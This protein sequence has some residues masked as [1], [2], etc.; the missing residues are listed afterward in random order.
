MEIKPNEHVALSTAS[1]PGYRYILQVSITEQAEEEV[2]QLFMIKNLVIT[3]QPRHA[4]EALYTNKCSYKNKSTKSV[5]LIIIYR[6]PGPYSEI[7]SKFTD[8]AVP[9]TNH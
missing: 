1:E 5:L 8:L 2:S 6:P 9:Y 4:I 7:F 3:Q